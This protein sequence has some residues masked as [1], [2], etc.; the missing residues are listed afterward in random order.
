MMEFVQFFL[1]LTIL[2]TWKYFLGWLGLYKH[3]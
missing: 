2:I 1:G 3:S